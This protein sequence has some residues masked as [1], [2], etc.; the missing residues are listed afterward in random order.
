M[1][2]E[3]RDYLMAFLIGAVAGIGAAML[4]SPTTKK[5]FVRGLPQGVKRFRKRGRRR[6]RLVPGR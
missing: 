5:R 2:S 3:R 1:P 6:H 4:F